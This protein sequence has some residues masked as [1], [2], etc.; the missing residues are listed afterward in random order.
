MAASSPASRE[1]FPGGM[2]GL[3][4]LGRLAGA[5]IRIKNFHRID[6]R[7][8]RHPTSTFGVDPTR[9]WS[10]GLLINKVPL[11]VAFKMYA[12]K[13]RYAVKRICY[14]LFDL[15][16]VAKGGSPGLPPGSTGA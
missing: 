10:P 16:F 14:F 8:S 6:S 15:F 5:A 4:P 2:D 9:P 7:Q 1:S 11:P 13:E 12:S 3:C